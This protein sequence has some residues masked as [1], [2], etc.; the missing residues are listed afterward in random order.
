MRRLRLSGATALLLALGATAPVHAAQD[1]PPVAI[2]GLDQRALALAGEVIDLAF[3]PDTRHAMMAR[4]VE[5]MMTQTRTAALAALETEL[6]DDVSRI[7]D[8]YMDRVRALSNRQIVEG[9]PAIFA[10]M[11]RAYAR[12]FTYAELLDIRAFVR[13]PTGMSFM[14]RSTELL[15]DPDVA[16]AN[17]AYMAATLQ[18]LQPLEAQLMEELRAYVESRGRHRDEPTSGTR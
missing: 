2:V 3:P 8:R 13:T 16:R 15:A 10:A 7:F 17:T 18:A 14:Q 4:A 11:I 5:S 12:A 9:S 1:T 6:D